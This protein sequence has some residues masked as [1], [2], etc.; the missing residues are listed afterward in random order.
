VEL[1]LPPLRER[2]DDLPELVTF[3]MRRAAESLSRTTPEL[4]RGALGKLLG[5]D[6]PGNVRQL[7][8]MLTKALVMAEGDRVTGRDVE[9][10]ESR[11]A[12]APGLTRVDFEHAEAERIAQALASNRW[13]VSKVS[14]LLDIPRPTL[15]RKIQKYGL[16]K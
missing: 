5:F 16:T 3:L 7:E 2:L 4:T 1:T 6:W 13:N 10:P 8:H 11:P 15:Y 14:R 9:L 12:P